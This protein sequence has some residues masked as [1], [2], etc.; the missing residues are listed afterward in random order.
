MLI[1]NLNLNHLR[2]FECVFR[3]KSMTLAADELHLTQSGVSQHIKTLEES[4]G[5]KLFDRVNQKLIPTNDGTVLFETCSPLFHKIE[6]TL[7]TLK[8]ENNRELLGTVSVGMPMEFGH[9]MIVPRISDL[10]KQHPGIKFRIRFGLADEMNNRILD[11][12]VDFAFVD[13]FGFDKRIETEVVFEEALELCVN[14]DVHKKL[15][16]M[17]NKEK[18]F[19]SLSLIEYH[20]NAP[21]VRMWLEH[22]YG[23][24]N[25]SLNVRARVPSV[26]GVAMFVTN[27]VG[28]AILPDH[29]IQKLINEGHNLHRIPASEKPL[30][31][32]ISI[33]HLAQRTHS[34]VSLKV[35]ELLT[36]SLK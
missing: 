22:H 11:G 28:A 20:E 23:L 26:V 8:G 18:F 35:R 2:I 17:D 10:S 7:Q 5:V 29:K 24:R 31:N 9:N 6:H 25:L 30:L 15:I 21:V 1:D 33:A 4:L 12:D 34:P 13:A 19:E 27:G 14:D 32:A 16:P 36:Q 3:T